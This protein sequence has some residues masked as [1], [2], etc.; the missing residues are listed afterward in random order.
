MGVKN[1][2]IFAYVL[3]GS[4]LCTLKYTFTGSSKINGAKFGD[5]CSVMADW[6]TMGW[7]FCQ[8]DLRREFQTEGQF[9]CLSLYSI[10]EPLLK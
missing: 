4:P 9:F 3:N 2:D 1:S 6:L 8:A 5:P 10:P 7:P